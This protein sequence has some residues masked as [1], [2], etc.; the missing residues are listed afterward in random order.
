ME[1][2]LGE[3]IRERREAQGLRTTDLAQLLQ[4]DKASYVSQLEAGRIGLPGPEVRRQLAKALGVTHLDILIAAGEI[5]PDEIEEAGKQGV[6][7]LD[8]ELQQVFSDMAQ[9]QWT[10]DRIDLMKLLLKDFAK[11]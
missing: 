2:P 11:G 6:T 1:K 8:P 3:W 5:R 7:T 10:D 4:R 9:M